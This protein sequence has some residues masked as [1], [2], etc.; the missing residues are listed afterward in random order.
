MNKV[1]LILALVCYAIDALK[2][3]IG[4]QSKIQWTPAGHAFIVLSLIL[5]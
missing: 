2:E 1:C 4:L 3:L 5:P